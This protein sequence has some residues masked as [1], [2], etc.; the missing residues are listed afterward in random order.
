VS[1]KKLDLL[2]LA[3]RRVAKPSTGPSQIVRC[4]LRHSDASGGFLYDVPNRFYGHPISPC[5]SY[6]VDP[7]KQLSSINS[8]CGEPIVQF[9]SHP[10]RN[11]YCSNVASLANLINNGPMLLA[12]LGMVQSQRHGFMPSQA[13]REQQC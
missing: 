2:Q 12:L 6:F 5:P 4:Q 7:A 13:A 11:W 1:Q 10:I 3:S 8:S 9:G